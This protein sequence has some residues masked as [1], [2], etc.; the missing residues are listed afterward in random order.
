[1]LSHRLTLFDNTVTLETLKFD[2]GKK[3][4]TNPETKETI[5]CK[6]TAELSFLYIAIHTT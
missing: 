2:F 3:E 6:L 5:H 4:K 1:M